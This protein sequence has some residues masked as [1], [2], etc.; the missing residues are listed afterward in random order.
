MSENF[1]DKIVSFVHLKIDD[2]IIAESA[3]VYINVDVYGSAV[4]LENFVKKSCFNKYLL[5]LK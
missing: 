2:V 4:K 3:D 1:S 5:H